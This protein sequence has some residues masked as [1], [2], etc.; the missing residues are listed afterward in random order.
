MNLNVILRVRKKTGSTAIS[1]IIFPMAMGP[2]LYALHRKFY[3]GNVEL[4][5]STLG[6][7]VL[8]TLVLT[9]TGFPVLAH[10]LSELKLLYTGLGE[11]ALTTAMLSDTYAW[12]LFTL[13]VPFSINGKGAIYSVVIDR[14]TENDE[15]DDNKL[16]FVV[17]GLLICSQITDVLGTHAVVGAFVY[18]LI[19]PHGKFADM[20]VSAS[21]DFAGG[22]LAPLFFSGTGMRLTIL[23][24]LL[25]TFFFGMRSRDGFALGLLLNT[26]GVIAFIMLNIAWDRSIISV[27]TYGVL[28]SSVL[29]MTIVVS[30]LINAIYKSRK[31]FEQNK[32]KT[33]Q[34]LRFDA[35]LR[36]LACVHNTRQATGITSLLESFNVTRLSPMHV[37]ALHLVELVGKVDVHSGEDIPTILNDLE[38]FGCDLYIVG[39]GNRR[40]LRVFSNLLEWCDCPELGALGDILA[41]NNFV[42]R[43]SVLVVQQYGYGGMVFGKQSNN[44]NTNNDG[45]EKV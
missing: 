32:L 20:V 24:T 45:F 6:A 10:T 43:S 36:I 40:N 9:V 42:S 15:W 28:T 41:S 8:W 35:E 39:Q 33:I 29:L 25:A 4:E 38:T 23:S 34:K 37:F 14:K 22:F 44:V 1:G 13:F 27:P 17:M 3:K 30:P 26:K 2:A 16:L 7:Y 19:L 5:E 21:D 12:V 11:A 18:G 31:R